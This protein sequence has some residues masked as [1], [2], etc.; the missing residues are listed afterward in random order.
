MIKTANQIIN[1]DGIMTARR[2]ADARRYASDKW[3]KTHEKPIDEEQVALFIAD[4]HRGVL[5]EEQKEFIRACR[6]D[7]HSVYNDMM[8]HL[9]QYY[10]MKRRGMV[11]DLISFCQIYLPENPRCA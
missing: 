10:E 1:E 7:M 6:S 9:L 5:T 3:N 2:F 8:I 11:S 4:E